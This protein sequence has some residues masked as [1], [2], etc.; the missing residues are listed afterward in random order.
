[1]SITSLRQDGVI[2]AADIPEEIDAILQEAVVL[3][4]QTDQAEATLKKA[5]SMALERLEVYIALYKFYFYKNRIDDAEEIALKALKEAARQGGFSSD[6][7]SLSVDSSQWTPATDV[8]RFFLYTLKA[9]AFINLRKGNSLL[10]DVLLKKL[11]E[12]DPKDQVGGSVIQD[13]ATGTAG[14]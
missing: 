12:L 5:F 7:A 14:E 10:A 2:F 3:Y 9:L 8:Q 13:L 6:W 4:E 1:M 11:L